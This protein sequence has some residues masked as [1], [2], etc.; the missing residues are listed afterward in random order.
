[1]YSLLTTKMFV[2]LNMSLD[3]KNSLILRLLDTE[4]LLLNRKSV[5]KQFN[6]ETACIIYDCLDAN[7]YK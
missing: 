6:T 4:K 1:M 7:K 5:L 2:K 3:T